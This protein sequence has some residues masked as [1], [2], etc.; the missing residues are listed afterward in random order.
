MDQLRDDLKITD[1]GP[2]FPRLWDQCPTSAWLELAAYPSRLTIATNR[3]GWRQGYSRQART[4]WKLQAIWWSRARWNTKLREH[5]TTKTKYSEKSDVSTFKTRRLGAIQVHEK[6]LLTILSNSN[7]STKST[8][9]HELNEL[10]FLKKPLHV[11][12]IERNGRAQFLVDVL[13]FW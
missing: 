9:H 1:A 7:K 13:K 6:F 10:V 5:P 3:A 12:G 11:R 8:I 2:N 4:M